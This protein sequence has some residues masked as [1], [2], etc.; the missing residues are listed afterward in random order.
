MSF[1]DRKREGRNMEW[2][3]RLRRH[4]EVRPLVM[5]LG[6]ADNPGSPPDVHVS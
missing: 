2:R 1:Q 6:H 5:T 3:R 4:R